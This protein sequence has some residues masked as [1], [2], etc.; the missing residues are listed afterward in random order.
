LINTVRKKKVKQKAATRTI[1]YE[2]VEFSVPA[3]WPVYWL[4]EDPDQCVRYDRNAVYVGNPGPDQDCPPG[5]VGRADTISIGGRAAPAGTSGPASLNTPASTKTAQAGQR[6]ALGTSREAANPALRPTAPGTIVQNQDLRE[7][8]VA[9]PV[10]LPWINATYGTDPAIV[11]QMLTTVR[12]VTPQ[13]AAP[14]A[15]AGSKDFLK[16]PT[17]VKAT[18]SGW[19]QPSASTTWNWS[20]GGAPE[21]SVSENIPSPGMPPGTDITGT[22]PATQAPQTPPPQVPAANPSPAQAAQAAQTTQAAQTAQAA[23]S[24]SLAG[25]D[26]CTAPSLQTMKAWRTAYAAT[27]IYIGGQMMGCDYGN[28]NASWVQQAVSMGWSLLPTFVGLQ[29]PCDSFSGKINPKRAASQG[30]AAANQAVANAKTFGIGTGSPIYYDM[31][32]YNRTNASCHTAVLTFL[33]AWDKQV[34]ADGYVSGVYSS[35][36]AAAKDL[37]TTTTIGGHPVAEPQAIWF[38]LW[39]KANNLTGSPYMNS[40]VWPASARSKQ[41]AGNRV[42]K[43]GRIALDIDVDWVNS[44]TV[45]G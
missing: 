3:S 40:S 43:V 33:S 37:Q 26:T 23:P 15:P 1:R 20:G 11:K 24:G 22:T 41:F 45:Q 4:D 25:F 5:L 17:P 44:P 13:S 16:L 12:Q 8:A 31:E 28:L 42:V 6:V 10:S 39:D 9:M 14:A 7:F 2:G 19:P 30:I 29:A 34:Q 35:A 27:A 21:T 32:G 38:A 36:D 18:T